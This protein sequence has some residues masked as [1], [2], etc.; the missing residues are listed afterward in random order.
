MSFDLLLESGND[1]K[2]LSLLG[3]Y[4]IWLLADLDR[5]VRIANLKI[6]KQSQWDDLI[7]QYIASRDELDRRKQALWSLS[8]KQLEIKQAQIASQ[9][10]DLKRMLD[11][12]YMLVSV[13]AIEPQTMPLP[14]G[15]KLLLAYFS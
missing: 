10:K 9:T 4:R 2:S 15:K 14:E 11:E 7:A 12:A 1:A 13:E 8:G 3:N 6:E 5:S